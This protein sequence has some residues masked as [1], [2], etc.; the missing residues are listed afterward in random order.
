MRTNET[1]LINPLDAAVTVKR[2][3]NKFFGKCVD[4]LKKAEGF[5]HLTTNLNKLKQSG[6][7]KVS[8][9]G[10]GGVVYA[11]PVFSDGKLHN[12]AAYLRDKE[13]PMFLKRRG[14]VD[15]KING[16]LIESKNE[17]NIGVVDYLEWGERY[18]ET[19]GGIIDTASEK[20]MIEELLVINNIQK[21]SK[22]LLSSAVL[23]PLY[24]ET[25]LETLF[26]GQQSNSNCELNNQTV[27]G[28]V[29]QL[30]PKLVGAFSMKHITCTLEELVKHIDI[31]V[32]VAN[33]KNNLQKYFISNENNLAG[34]T[35]FRNGDIRE[36]LDIEL[37]KQLWTEASQKRYSVL[38][39]PIPKG[40]MGILPTGDFDFYECDIQNEKCQKLQKLDLH[41]RKELVTQET[42]LRSPNS[43]GGINR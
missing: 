3:D 14:I 26:R 22:L 1:N 43:V 10:L 40:E 38:T 27:K 33:L 16:I 8:S 28:I 19:A 21:I 41:I 13:M 18:N 31:D 24:F 35:L 4:K 9:G 17:L 37:A 36:Y 34:H 6:E 32:F 12:L 23:R 39:Y 11:A 30:N 29:F 7:L 25:I 2:Y 20:A 5:L 42:V 15:K